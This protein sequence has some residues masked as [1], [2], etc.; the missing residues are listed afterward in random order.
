MIGALLG[1]S[2]RVPGH[3][4]AEPSDISEQQH[5]SHPA[6]AVLT[7]R[8]NVRIERKVR[9]RKDWQSAA[10]RAVLT[11]NSGRPECSEIL[12]RRLSR[13]SGASVVRRQGA[14]Y[15]MEDLNVEICQ[16]NSVKVSH[17]RCESGTAEPKR[18]Q[19]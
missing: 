3:A 5:S 2:W 12:P 1:H 10:I 16:E 4:V 8:P 11:V 6:E 9:R 17:Y 15:R 14:A 19:A 7:V 13:R 18:A